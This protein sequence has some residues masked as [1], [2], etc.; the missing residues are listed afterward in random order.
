M[1]ALRLQTQETLILLIEKANKLRSSR[2]VAQID[3]LECDGR[4]L[5]RVIGQRN[6]LV[7]YHEYDGRAFIRE[8][9]TQHMLSVAEKQQLTR[10]RN[11]DAYPG[12]WRC[13]RCGFS[14]TRIGIAVATDQGVHEL[15]EC[16]CG[17]Q[18]WPA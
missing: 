12:P 14:P 13:D 6:P 3:V 7:A 15:L 2:F 18:F 8:G 5:V 4:R 9:T 1:A 10:R 16:H 11:R 17:G